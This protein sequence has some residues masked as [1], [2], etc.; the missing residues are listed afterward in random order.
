MKGTKE[1][2]REAEA[3]VYWES[4]SRAHKFPRS[5]FWGQNS[6]STRSYEKNEK[7]CFLCHYIDWRRKRTKKRD[8]VRSR[9]NRVTRFSLGFSK[10]IN[11]WKRTL[12]KTLLVRN[13]D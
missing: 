10:I 2:E 7:M 3:Y 11:F 8:R 4:R 9:E 1:Q 5:L 13:F 6:L 12:R